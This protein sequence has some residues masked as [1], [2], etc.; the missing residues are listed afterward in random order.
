MLWFAT[1]QQPYIW[2]WPLGDLNP[3]PSGYEPDALP[4]E[5]KGHILEAEASLITFRYG[6]Y[7]RLRKSCHQYHNT[8][9]NLL[10]QVLFLAGTKGLEPLTSLLESGIFPIKLSP[11]MDTEWQFVSI[12]LLISAKIYNIP[13]Y[14]TL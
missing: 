7:N 13:K 1:H 2:W 10:C 3:G 5:L 8:F 4:T 12:L 11:Y 6:L 14:S 9:F